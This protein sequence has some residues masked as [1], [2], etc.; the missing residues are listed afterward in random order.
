MAL[1]S[2]LGKESTLPARPFS[3]NVICF[4]VF[5]QKLHNVRFEVFTAVNMKNIV[6]WDV[7]PSGSG[8]N[9]RFGGTYRL[10]LQGR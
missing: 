5:K 6:F 1:S 2:L 7:A 8:L 9:R 3:V 10:H 4:A